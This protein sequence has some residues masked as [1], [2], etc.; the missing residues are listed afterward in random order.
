M[1]TSNFPNE[2]KLIEQLETPEKRS[3]ALVA[4]GECLT[5]ED[6]LRQELE[7]LWDDCDSSGQAYEMY[8]GKISRNPIVKSKITGRLF[9]LPWT[10]IIRLA[11]AKG[12]DRLVTD[13]ETL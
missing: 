2:M 1:D 3:P 8:L 9:A 11:Q 10:E 5:G 13:L 12:I 7:Y 4:A 6:L